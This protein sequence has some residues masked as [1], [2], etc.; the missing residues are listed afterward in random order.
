MLQEEKVLHQLVD[1][2][3]A[4]VRLSAGD[5]VKVFWRSGAREFLHWIFDDSA[6]YPFQLGIISGCLDDTDLLAVIAEALESMAMGWSVEKF[7]DAAQICVN[8]HCIIHLL[9]WDFVERPTRGRQTLESR[10]ILWRT[11]SEPDQYIFIIES[12]GVFSEDVPNSL[13][14]PPFIADVLHTWAWEL[15]EDDELLKLRR[16]L[17]MLMF[18]RRQSGSSLSVREHLRDQPY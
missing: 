4:E 5:L 2:P 13:F 14:I 3:C 1:K 8:R 18:R 9:G 12:T 10:P 15:G 7:E 16:Y 11:H 6:S 17:D